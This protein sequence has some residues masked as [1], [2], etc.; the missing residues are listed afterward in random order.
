MKVDVEGTEGAVFGSGRR[1]L[2]TF[3]P[4]I[5]CE[6]LLGRADGEGLDVLLEPARLRRYLVTDAALVERERIVPDER[7][8]DWLFWKRSPAELRAWGCR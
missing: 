4:D 1:L 5:L 3:R 2:E 6:V 7:C 8:R